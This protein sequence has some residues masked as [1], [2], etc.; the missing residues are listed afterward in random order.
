MA[1]YDIFSKRQKRLRGEVPDVYTY[2]EIPKA[3]R[4][5]I[6]LTLQRA[7]LYEEIART[8]VESLRIEYGVYTLDG[9][10]SPV[11][12]RGTSFYIT[13]LFR[14]ISETHRAEHVL[15]ATELALLYHEEVVDDINVRFKEHGLGYQFET[16]KIVRIDSQ[17]IHQEA[18]KPAF[19]LL[20]DPAYASAQDEFLTAHKH[21][22]KGDNKEAIIGACKA[23]EST[24]KIICR[25]RGWAFGDN[26]TA[27]KLIGVCL[28]NGLVPLSLQ[29][30]MNGGLIKTLES[31]VPTIR[32]DNAHPKEVPTEVPDYL[33]SYVLHMTAS[34]IVFLV[35][36]EQALG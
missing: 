18:V 19:S 29:D 14:F 15:D 13:E 2:D 10:G 1:I 9:A 3:L 28:K 7:P 24:M 26:D 23:F 33:T 36:A 21:Y 27:R 12:A 6:V 31:C 30:F 17:F 4:T 22:R 32:N 20:S 16:D 5:Q 34:I 35:K 11:E 25:K 8:V